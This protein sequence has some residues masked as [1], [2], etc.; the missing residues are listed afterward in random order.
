MAVDGAAVL[1]AVDVFVAAVVVV[2]AAAVV[3]FVAA[4]SVT[5]CLRLSRERLDCFRISI[6]TRLFAFNQSPTSVW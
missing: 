2:V 4:V 1:A 5:I 6:T 3:V